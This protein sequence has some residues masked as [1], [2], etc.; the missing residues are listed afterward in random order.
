MKPKKDKEREEMERIF[1]ETFTFEN[2]VKQNG[3][4]SPF[5]KMLSFWQNSERFPVN[6]R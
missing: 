6:R 1:Q 5:F 3:G 2:V 4:C